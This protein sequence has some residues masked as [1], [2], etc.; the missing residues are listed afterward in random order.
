[1][2]RCSKIVAETIAHSE[3]DPFA[4]YVHG[5]RQDM[6]A[7]LLMATD[8]ETSENAKVSVRKA[9]IE[10]RGKI[11]VALGAAIDGRGGSSGIEGQLDPSEV[12][13]WSAEKRARVLEAL[14]MPDE[15]SD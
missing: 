7:L 12:G 13:H 3:I 11:A 6:K 1:V 9:I 8:G 5:L 4:E 10:V 14:G 15:E 2:A